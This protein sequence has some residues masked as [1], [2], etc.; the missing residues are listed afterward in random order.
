MHE[1]WNR[2]AGRILASERLRNYY[3]AWCARLSREQAVFEV[4]E[5]EQHSKLL[6]IIS[7]L[8]FLIPHAQLQRV[9]TL[10][11]DQTV[12]MFQWDKLFDQLQDEWINTV[13]I[14]SL[15]HSPW[16]YTDRV[17]ATIILAGNCAFLAIPLSQ[18]QGFVDHSSPE[19]IGSY[20]SLT[21]SLF[22]LIL[23]M[24]MYRHHKTRKPQNPDELVRP[25]LYS[26]YF[27][28]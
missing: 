13:L 6:D 28:F 17:Q 20:L 27:I 4:T 11:V 24:V 3:G 15:L 2:T 5:P 26:C 25:L 21:A 9:R 18:G 16:S 19:Q 14:V 8:L 1:D 7:P 22:S 10:I 23:G 12:I